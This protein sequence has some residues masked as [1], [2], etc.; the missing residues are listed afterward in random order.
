MGWSARFSENLPNGVTGPL[1]GR[2]QRIVLL[3]FAHQEDLAFR[4][5]LAVSFYKSLARYL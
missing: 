3:Q 4:V 2:V 1:L 5:H